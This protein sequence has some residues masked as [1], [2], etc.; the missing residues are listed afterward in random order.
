MVQLG[1]NL[2]PVLIAEDD[3]RT[4]EF[5]H[6]GDLELDLARMKALHA[7]QPLSLTA[8]ECQLFN[9]SHSRLTPTASKPHQPTATR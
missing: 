1:R 4:S 9:R 6:V 3:P 2:M 5:F 7:G 8:K